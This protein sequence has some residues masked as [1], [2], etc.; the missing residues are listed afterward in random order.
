METTQNGLLSGIIEEAQQKAD[1]I[2][3][4]AKADAQKI[5]EE[6]E[7]KALV[8]I[9]SQKREL[10]QKLK[11]IQ[12]R[13]QANYGSAKRKASLKE[14]DERYNQVRQRLVSALDANT[15]EPHLAKWIAEAAIGLDLKEAKVAFSRQCPVTT[16]HLQEAARL[17]KEATGADVSLVLDE[18]P[19]RS[20]GVIVSSLD[21]SLSFN[22][23]VEVRLRRFD[24]IIR[25]VIQEHS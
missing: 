1:R 15:I 16:K 2:L 22:N 13:L 21:G 19:I 24:R 7:Q 5:A 11:Q 8:E 3:E 4:E 25:Q 17:V 9:E 14:I 6:A 23:Q 12:M 20:L 10:E 18:K